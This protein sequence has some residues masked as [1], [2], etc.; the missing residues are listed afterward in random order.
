MIF[1]LRA[2]QVLL[3]IFTFSELLIVCRR[4]SVRNVIHFL[5]YALFAM[6]AFILLQR[7]VSNRQRRQ[8]RIARNN[9]DWRY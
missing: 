1:L 5:L 8:H 6:T 2:L 4:P 9:Q 7:K 3:V